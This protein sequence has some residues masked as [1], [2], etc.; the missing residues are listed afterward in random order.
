MGQFTDRSDGSWVT[1]YDPLSAKTL[2]ESLVQ[3]QD[4]SVQS[5]DQHQDCAWVPGLETRSKTDDILK[6]HNLY[7]REAREL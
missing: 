7:V 2:V 3:D 1:K 5:G 6:R 4:H